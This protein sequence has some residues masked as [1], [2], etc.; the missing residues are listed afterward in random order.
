MIR[1]TVLRAAVLRA[2]VLRRT[3]LGGA[4]LEGAV[5]AGVALLVLSAPVAAQPAVEFFP[6]TRFFMGA[7]H[8]S[9][10]SVHYKWRADFHGDVD[11][12]SWAHGG[13]VTFLANYEVVLGNDFR[14]F[15]PE[16]GNYAL[17]GSISQQ[18]RGVE[19]SA[20]F[21]HLS[22]HLSDRGKRQAVDWNTWGVRAKREFARAPV[23]LT[24][25][26]DFRGVVAKSF[27]DYRTETE[28]RASLL[29]QWRPRIGIIADAKVRVVGVDGSRNR[30][31]QSEVRAEG[32][33]RLGGA[34][35]AVE[36][37]LAGERRLDPDVLAFGGRTWFAAGFRLRSR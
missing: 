23:V 15:D 35:G 14:R 26:G 1:R 16:Q 3:A 9:T 32:G 27:V 5:L 2:A 4:A 20:V 37:F 25:Q 33:V 24:V 7:E 8:L 10:D 31:T 34:G 22:R 21:H 19:V 18:V 36:L 6:A 28:G 13:R 17:D 11:L 12:A 29:Y 30:G